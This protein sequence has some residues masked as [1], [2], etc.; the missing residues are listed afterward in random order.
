MSK[1]N[2]HQLFEESKKEFNANRSL[3]PGNYL[4]KILSADV[5][6]Q[7]YKFGNSNTIVKLQTLQI[8]FEVIM[9]KRKGFTNKLILI[10]DPRYKDKTSDKNAGYKKFMTSIYQ[11]G[12]I[13]EMFGI[14]WQYIE[15]IKNSSQELNGKQIGIRAN[16]VKNEQ[17]IFTYYNIITSKEQVDLLY[18]L[19]EKE[20]KSALAAQQKSLALSPK[21]T[22]L[23]S[24]ASN[25]ENKNPI[26][27]NE[28]DT[29]VSDFIIDEL[30]SMNKD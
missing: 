8:S 28:D 13:C 26:F 20:F 22:P 27:I 21:Y 12:F 5:V 18:E 23:N 7:D 24:F 16:Q 4:V 29:T 25:N 15:Q 11:L 19:Q 10:L 6:L 30:D 3:E 9:G 2:Y 14:P 1:I 17:G